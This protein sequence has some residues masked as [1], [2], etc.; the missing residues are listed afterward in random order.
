[1]RQQLV[2]EESVAPDTARYGGSF[3]PLDRARRRIR[4]RALTVD[5]VR[6]A[7]SQWFCR[8]YGRTAAVDHLEE[9]AA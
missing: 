8:R 6:Y 7:L 1:M 4:R 9:A 5:Q 2:G 3:F